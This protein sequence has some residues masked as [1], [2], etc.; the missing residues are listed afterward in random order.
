[1]TAIIDLY[2]R[3]DE[4]RHRLLELDVIE[5][6][7]YVDFT[8]DGVATPPDERAK[9]NLERVKLRAEAEQVNQALHAAKKAQTAW[10]NATFHQ[11]LVGMLI[12]RGDYELLREA[13][14]RTGSHPAIPADGGV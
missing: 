5:A 10:R 11:I 2:K 8:T 14:R 12:E 9:L 13:G 1:M 3:R 6:Q 4:I 7:R